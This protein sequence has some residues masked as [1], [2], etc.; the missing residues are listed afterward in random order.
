[1][2]KATEKF[3]SQQVNTPSGQ[4]RSASDGHVPRGLDVS[5]EDYSTYTAGVKYPALVKYLKIA[6]LC[7]VGTVGKTTADMRDIKLKPPNILIERN[8]DRNHRMKDIRDNM[9]GA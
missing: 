1:M 7:K 9:W 5:T 3:L 8:I 2:H 6:R 4:Q